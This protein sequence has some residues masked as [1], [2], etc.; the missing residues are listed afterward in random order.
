M[1]AEGGLIQYIAQ[2]VVKWITQERTLLAS[3]AAVLSILWYLV[4]LYQKTH[5]FFVPSLYQKYLNWS[6]ER[7]YRKLESMF[8]DM[9]PI[10]EEYMASVHAKYG[11]LMQSHG[12]TLKHAVAENNEFKAHVSGS[13]T[14]VCNDFNDLIELMSKMQADVASLQDSVNNKQKI[15]EEMVQLVFKNL[16]CCP[17]IE[18]GK[19]PCQEK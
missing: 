13:L 3:I 8:E 7:K 17:L 5:G 1:S 14:K 11:Q 10:M 9:R 19:V 6:A 16:D 2:E 15:D 4:R 18:D 12:L